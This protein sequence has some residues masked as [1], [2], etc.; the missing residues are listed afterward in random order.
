[1]SVALLMFQYIKACPLIDPM[2]RES[3]QAWMNPFEPF[4]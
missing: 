3:L 1:M 2:K 4:V